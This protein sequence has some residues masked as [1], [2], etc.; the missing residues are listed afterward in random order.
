MEP[1]R[2]YITGPN[3]D[4]M[5]GM[6]LGLPK[7]GDPLQLFLEDGKLMRTSIVRKV[8]RRGPELVVETQN[9]KYRVELTGKAS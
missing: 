6:M 3:L 5:P 4:H 2:A 1:Q 9:S 7:V 8:S